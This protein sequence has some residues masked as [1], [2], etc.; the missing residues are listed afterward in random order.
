MSLFYNTSSSNNNVVLTVHNSKKPKSTD[1]TSG[2]Q[3]RAW[4]DLNNTGERALFIGGK[5]GQS[6]GLLISVNDK[7]VN[8]ID[9][10]PQLN[11]PST[12]Y[13]AVAVDIDYNGYSDLIVARE[14]GVTLYLNHGR[15][16]FTVRK[17]LSASPKTIP[18]SLAV[19]DYNK[20]G[21]VDIYVS[22]HT[23]PKMLQNNPNYV[24]KNILLE[25]IGVGVFEDVTERTWSGG[26]NKNT[27]SATWLDVNNDKLPD[28]ILT[29]NDGGKEVYQNT[30]GASG[31]KYTS[32]PLFYRIKP[33]MNIMTNQNKTK[34]LLK[35]SSD[36][37]L[38]D[39]N[40]KM[41]DDDLN[42]GWQVLT[43]KDNAIPLDR[44]IKFNK[45]EVGYGSDL[46][47]L[48]VSG[49]QNIKSNKN[50]FMGVKLPNTIPFINA[51]I[52]IASIDDRTGKIRRQTKQV[53][54]NSRSPSNNITFFDLKND[55]RVLYLEVN[56]IYDGNH[57]RHPRPMMNT[58][59]TFRQMKSTYYTA[60]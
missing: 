22:Q 44:H 8:I 60:L 25:G 52:H 37:K 47:W 17:I 57:W 59:A 53:T 26:T 35:G 1:I 34:F 13:A 14:D 56:T 49:Q 58:I 42:L 29:Q 27:A 9:Q 24:A 48:N 11:S 23:H 4:I 54:N 45:N 6:D 19:T 18:I 31:A 16:N 50:N 55:T 15:G 51:S 5:Q 41:I 2:L 21:H 28:L 32:G 3:A 33:P 43:D 46:Y 36:F 10:I 38:N 20:D 40:Q 12:T 30:R 39:V 7:M